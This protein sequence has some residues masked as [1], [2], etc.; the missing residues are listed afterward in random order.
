MITA[1]DGAMLN[2]KL[3]VSRLDDPF[4]DL[5]ERL[6]DGTEWIWVD[7]GRPGGARMRTAPGAAMLDEKVFV[8]TDDGTLWE[9][10][11]RADL[12][13]WVW[14]D[15]GRPDNQP[16]VHAPGAAMLNEK[17]FVVTDQGNL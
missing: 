14:E 9:R 11:W 13:Q 8:A 3:F 6:W 17:L 12:D 7:H 16:V 5:Y 4:P 2:S 10:H 1:P 15:H